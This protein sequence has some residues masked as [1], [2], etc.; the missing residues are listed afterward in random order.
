MK[1]IYK[2][3]WDKN[4]LAFRRKVI[5]KE[6]DLHELANASEDSLTCEKTKRE[7]EERRKQLIREN[8]KIAPES[9]IDL[10]D[11]IIEVPAMESIRSYESLKSRS[12]I[13]E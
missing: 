2:Q 13:L 10:E 8:E 4:N 12:D 3:F 9:P 7:E 1:L 11:D 6:F 5:N